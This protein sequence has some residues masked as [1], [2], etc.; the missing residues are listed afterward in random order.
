[1]RDALCLFAAAAIALSARA[2]DSVALLRSGARV[3]I[4]DISAS[5]VSLAAARGKPGKVESLSHVKDVTG[6]LAS[7]FEANRPL[8]TDLWRASGRLERGDEGGAEPLYESLWTRSVG[9]DGPTRAEIAAGLA[10]CRVR[11]GAYATAVDP[12]LEWLRQSG[13]LST[14]QLAEQRNRL[15]ISDSAEFWID[16]LPPVWTDSTAVRSLASHAGATRPGGAPHPNAE[17]LLLIYQTAARRETGQLWQVDPQH[18]IN[19]P[20]WANLAG[21]MVLAEADNA[22]VRAEARQRLASRLV[23]DVAL[24]KQIWIRLALGRSLM[25]E[26]GADD[27]RAGILNL[28]WIVSREAPPTPLLASAFAGAI[29]GLVLIADLDGARSLLADAERRLPGDPVLDSPVIASARRAT[30]RAPT[31]PSVPSPDKDK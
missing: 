25:L 31:P 18:A 24:W 7:K 16:V 30:A 1:M 29:K 23:P 17:D 5:G 26:P 9:V 27:R 22:E 20:A 4:S 10:A 11:R 8:A 2:E 14:D 19:D 12:W 3:P 28:L 13:S 15:G 21:E 6:P